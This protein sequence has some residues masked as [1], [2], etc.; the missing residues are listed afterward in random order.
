MGC[1]ISERSSDGVDL[2]GRRFSPWCACACAIFDLC[3]LIRSARHEIS[4][5]KPKF[6]NFPK[7]IV[8]MPSS[9]RI[10]VSIRGEE[11]QANFEEHQVVT[12]GTKTECWIESKEDVQFSIIIDLAPASGRTKNLF[13]FRSYVDGIRVDNALLGHIEGRFYQNA[14]ASGVWHAQ[15]EIKPLI[16]GKTLFMG[17]PSRIFFD[18]VSEEGQNDKNVL[19]TLGT[20]QIQVYRVKLEGKSDNQTIRPFKTSESK[21]VTEKAKKALI[22]HSVK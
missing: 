9:G 1:Q 4:A 22:T 7:S 3:D 19:D 14:I 8:L 21:G 17:I 15:N 16:F 20:I 18:C 10:G 2:Y 13:S 6:H 12:T 5:I 11:T